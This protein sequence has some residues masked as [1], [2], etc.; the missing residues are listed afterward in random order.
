MRGVPINPSSVSNSEVSESALQILAASPVASS[1]IS[2]SLE[3]QI[4][5]S[6]VAQSRSIPY[7]DLSQSFRLTGLVRVMEAALRILPNVRPI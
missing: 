1:I 3:S 2:D 4:M 5:P 6:N 7:Q